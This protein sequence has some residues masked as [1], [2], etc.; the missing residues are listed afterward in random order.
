MYPWSG[1]FEWGR[2]VQVVWDTSTATVLNE[3]LNHCRS[4]PL[5]KL[6]KANVPFDIIGITETSEQKD[7]SFLTNVD[8]EG[9]DLY[10][11]PTNS[12]KGGCCIYANKNLD[13]FERSDLKIQND[14]F[15]TTWAEIKNKKSKN[16]LIGCI[17]RSPNK[18]HD[19]TDFLIHLDSILKK[20][21]KENKEI[22]I[23]G[24]NNIDLLKTDKGSFYLW[25]VTASF[26]HSAL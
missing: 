15:Q 9:Y 6:F 8:M 14:H 5:F 20:L 17:Y 25:I 10:H 11:T 23:C 2:D 12:A 21:T 4:W 24:D 1:R 13:V 22:Y 26:Y 18:V 16:I 3:W 19:V 7:T